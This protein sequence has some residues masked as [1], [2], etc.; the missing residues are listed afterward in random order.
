MNIR[1]ILM[2]NGFPQTNLLKKNSSSLRS[3]EPE[4]KSV[5]F[6]VLS[7]ICGIREKIISLL[8]ELNIKVALKPLYTIANFVR[9]PKDSMKK[10][11]LVCFIKVLC[12]DCNFIYISQTK[13]SL[14]SR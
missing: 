12:A 3:H 5:A 10:D 14:K 13:Q 7:Y 4:T 6:I 1:R 8:N 2:H 9:S 11:E